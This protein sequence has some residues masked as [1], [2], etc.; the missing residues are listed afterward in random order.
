[1]IY[2]YLLLDLWGS[3][4]QE[5]QAFQPVWWISSPRLGNFSRLTTWPTESCHVT[6]QLTN[7]QPRFG[8]HDTADEDLNNTL[9][10][11]CTENS[12]QIFPEMKHTCCCERF[13]YI[14]IPT[15]G[16]PIV[17][18]EN[19]WGGPIAEIYKSLTDTWMRKLELRGHAVSYLGGHKSDFLCSS[20]ADPWHFGVDPDPDPRI[21][22][23]D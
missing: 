22:A 14:P 21:H 5:L 12:K 10:R 1:M 19:R 6:Q 7:E 15:I 3:P 13:L 4:W 17:L 11:Q 20:I 18:Q 8:R 23:P 2:S 16:L 9:Q